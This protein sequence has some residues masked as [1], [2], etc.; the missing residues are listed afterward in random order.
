MGGFP[1]DTNKPMSM[2]KHVIH[3]RRIN[4]MSYGTSGP[5]LSVTFEENVSR[6]LVVCVTSLRDGIVLNDLLIWD[7]RIH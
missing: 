6:V 1:G 4:A 7:G 2:Q 5:M 3:I